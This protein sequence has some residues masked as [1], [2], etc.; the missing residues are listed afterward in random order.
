MF[1][2]FRFVFFGFANRNSAVSCSFQNI[3]VLALANDPLPVKEP[4]STLGIYQNCLSPKTKYGPATFNYIFI[5]NMYV[6]IGCY[7]RSWVQTT[8]L[9]GNV[10]KIQTTDVV[11]GIKLMINSMGVV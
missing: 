1:G 9:H 7:M 8:V 3:T 2:H 11:Y 6:S 10:V 4:P 5:A